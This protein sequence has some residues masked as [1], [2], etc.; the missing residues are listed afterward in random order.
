MSFN[1]QTVRP[2]YE[3]EYNRFGDLVVQ[4]D[5]MDDSHAY[6][7]AAGLTQNRETTFTYDAFGRRETRVLPMGQTERF[8]YDE[9]G[10]QYLRIDS[11]PARPPTFEPRMLADANKGREYRL[12][13]DPFRDKRLSASEIII[14]Y[15]RIP[16]AES[17][18]VISFAGIVDT[19]LATK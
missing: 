19:W 8:R 14:A 15:S 12:A 2:R 16:D 1:G 3:Y 7:G 11:A 9:L 17:I 5:A 6:A 4:R 13:S 18:T 10:R